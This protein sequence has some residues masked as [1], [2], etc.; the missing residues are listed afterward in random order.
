MYGARVDI[1]QRSNEAHGLYRADSTSGSGIARHTTS[2]A[3]CRSASTVSA[4]ANGTAT[5]M[6]AGASARIA[7][8]RQCE[9]DHVTASGVMLQGLRE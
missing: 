3:S 6:P 5:T 4:G 9:H 8:T 2:S 1:C 7:A